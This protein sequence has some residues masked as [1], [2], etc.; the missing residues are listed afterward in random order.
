LVSVS[1]SDLDTILNLSGQVSDENLEAILDLA[2]DSLNIF[3][4]SLSNMTG[5]AGTKTVDLTS[6][7]RGAVLIVAREIY[8]KFYKG[9]GTATATGGFTVTVGDLLNDNDLA[10]LLEKLGEKLAMSSTSVGVA[11]SVAEDTSGIE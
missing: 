5:T 9:A 10:A 4:A 6:Q 2:I 8:N 3:G 11:F 7:Q 1:A